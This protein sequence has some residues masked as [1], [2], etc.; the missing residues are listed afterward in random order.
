ML[1]TTVPDKPAPAA[2]SATV[3]FDGVFDSD[4]ALRLR[5]WVLKSIRQTCV[6]VDL[7]AVQILRDAALQILADTMRTAGPVALT[8]RGLGQHLRRILGY[9]GVNAVEFDRSSGSGP[10]EP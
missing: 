3:E 9:L 5:E 2:E 1:A 10:I 6:V 4:T 8:V 7:T